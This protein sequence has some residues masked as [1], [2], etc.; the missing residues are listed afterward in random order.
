MTTPV[1]HVKSSALSENYNSSHGPTKHRKEA[2]GY[3]NGRLCIFFQHKFRSV[4]EAYRI[5]ATVQS[6]VSEL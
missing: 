2:I 3:R 1:K 4:L 6:A 5:S